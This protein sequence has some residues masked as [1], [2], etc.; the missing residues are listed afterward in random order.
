MACSVRP[1]KDGVC[2]AEN[3]PRLSAGV[4][5]IAVGVAQA[6]RTAVH[7]RSGNP[8]RRAPEDLRAGDRLAGLRWRRRGRQRH[9]SGGWHRRSRGRRRRWGAAVRDARKPVD[10][11]QHVQVGDEAFRAPV[12]H[13]IPEPGSPVP[14]VVQGLAHGLAQHLYR[15]A[16]RHRAGASA[17]GVR[18]VVHHKGRAIIVRSRIDGPGHGRARPNHRGQRDE[19]T[20]GSKRGHAGRVGPCVKPHNAGS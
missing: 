2:R 9:R 18:L 4:R 3:P 15:C 13:A 12:A 8:V 14:R 10:V 5:A 11:G 7:H 19:S 20:K 17:S 16:R 1:R 6:G